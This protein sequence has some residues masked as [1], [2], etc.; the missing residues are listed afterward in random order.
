[1]AAPSAAVSLPPF[2]IQFQCHGKPESE[3]AANAVILP[4]VDYMD[5]NQPYDEWFQSLEL[6]VALFKKNREAYSGLEFGGR[7]PVCLWVKAGMLADGAPVTAIDWTGRHTADG[8][9]FRAPINNEYVTLLNCK[10]GYA[11]LVRICV[12]AKVFMEVMVK[13]EAPYWPISSGII[14]AVV[15]DDDYKA[16]RCDA[17]LKAVRDAALSAMAE[18]VTRICID[19]R[20]C[21]DAIACLVGT[22]LQKRNLFKD[23]DIETIQHEWEGSTFPMRIWESSETKQMRLAAEESIIGM[24]HAHKK[25]ADD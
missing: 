11:R 1:M 4:T 24:L 10:P 13:E 22:A 7:A 16:E 17:V 18:G 21:P 15:L 2:R 9:S 25:R 19:C 12:L 6:A 3:V 23:M 14:R 8:D 20:H 5:D